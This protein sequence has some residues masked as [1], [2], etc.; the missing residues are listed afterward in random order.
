M[1]P[2]VGR[3]GCQGTDPSWVPRPLALLVCLERPDPEL[4]GRMLEKSCDGVTG[5]TE[6]QREARTCP[7]LG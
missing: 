7:G 2:W 3:D 4:L 5:E 1:C 6:T